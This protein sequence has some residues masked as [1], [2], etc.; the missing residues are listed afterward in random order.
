MV[1]CVSRFSLPLRQKGPKMKLGFDFV[2]R[3][4]SEII[5]YYARRFSCGIKSPEDLYHDLLISVVE[6]DWNEEPTTCRASGDVLPINPA[7]VNTFIRSRAMDSRRTES[8]RVVSAE[9]HVHI[10]G[11]NLS[12]R[13]I[14]TLID[15]LI[16]ECMPLHRRVIKELADPSAVTVRLSIA[17]QEAARAKAAS[18]QFALNIHGEPKV[19]SKHVAQTLGVPQRKVSDAVKDVRELFVPAD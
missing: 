6:C 16:P 3:N 19:T 18:G 2:E 7:K 13:D 1:K 5:W 4:F 9:V 17:D 15:E 11:R 12:E 8:R 14:R 10:V